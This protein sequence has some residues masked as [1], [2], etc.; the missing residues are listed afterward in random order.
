MAGFVVRYHLALFGVYHAVFLLQARHGLFD[1]FAEVC[2]RHKAA[3][4]THRQQRRFV[5]N[6][7]QVG[8]GKARRTTRDGG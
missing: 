2:L 5:D 1:S 7:G 3:A 8:A 4:G 6:V